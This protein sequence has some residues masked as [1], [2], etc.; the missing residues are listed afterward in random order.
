MPGFQRIGVSLATAIA[1]ISVV[2]AG[3]TIWLL[4]TDP[5]TVATAVNEGEI[6]PFIRQ[7]AAAIFE[8]MKGLL[9][10]L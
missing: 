8:A 6:T 5:A 4:L 9:R 2:L 7:L 1:F 3:A 10:Y